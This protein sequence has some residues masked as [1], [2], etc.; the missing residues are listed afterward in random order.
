MGNDP[1]GGDI[2]HV[3]F[4][5]WIWDTA[6]RVWR[7]VDPAEYLAGAPPARVIPL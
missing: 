4:E 7:K 3:H 1:S 5:L 6:E 2:I